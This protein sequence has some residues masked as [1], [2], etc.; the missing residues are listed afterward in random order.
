MQSLSRIVAAMTIA[1][2]LSVGGLS[3][4]PAAEAAPTT[5]YARCNNGITLRDWTGKNPKD[6][7]PFGVYWLYKQT[8][9]VITPIMK[10]SGAPKGSPLWD[11][12][13]AGY[14]AA[15]KWCSNNSLTCG[16]VTAA[17]VTIVAGLI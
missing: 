1:A 11:A 4:A 17:G 2:G 15:Q 9:N 7:T 16:I 12:I 10:I 13:K 6:C 8:G 3:A 14:S 5:Y